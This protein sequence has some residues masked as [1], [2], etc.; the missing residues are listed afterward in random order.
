MVSK[1][2]QRFERKTMICLS[3]SQCCLYNSLSYPESVKKRDK[4]QQQIPLV[5]RWY[6]VFFV[7]LQW[8]KGQVPDTKCNQGNIRNVHFLLSAK[9]PTDTLCKARDI[10]HTGDTE[11]VG[12]CKKLLWYK[13]GKKIKKNNCVKTKSHIRE[14]LNLLTC[15]DSSNNTK[16]DRN[17][18]K[19][20]KKISYVPCHMSWVMCQRPNAILFTILKILLRTYW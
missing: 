7:F 18:Q 11:S 17:Q 4:Q 12:V 5:L 2:L 15:A 14:T 16:T 13:K 10:P 1:T 9:S 6:L 19:K 3:K 20:K 8:G